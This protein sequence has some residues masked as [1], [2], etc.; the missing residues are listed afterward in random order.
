MFKYKNTKFKYKNTKFKKQILILFAPKSTT[1]DSRVPSPCW[2]KTCMS[3]S[4]HYSGKLPN[5]CYG[6]P[7]IAVMT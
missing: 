6:A 3:A 2:Y 4:P 1:A 7:C 5:A